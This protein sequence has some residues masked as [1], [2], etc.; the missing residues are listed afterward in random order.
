MT[1]DQDAF[2]DEL[3]AGGPLPAAVL[4]DPRLAPER[5]ALGDTQ[6]WLLS[7]YRSSEISGAL[8]FGRLAR[9]QAPGPIQED[10]TRHFADEAQ[11]ARYWTDCIAELG[12]SALK[13]G[14]SYQDQYLAAAGLPANL[15]EVLAITS[16]FERRV[17]H[18]YARHLAVPGLPDAVARTLTRIM[19]DERWHISWVRGALKDLEGE[20]GAEHVRATVRRYQQADREVYAATL[21]EH[22]DRLGFLASRAGSSR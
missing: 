3:A 20:Y 8:F 16:V 5:S 6:R 15:M 14:V 12:G 2:E 4:G 11:H 22:E 9:A 13:L 1:A 10:L 18:Q 19:E 21:R 7:Y 17:V